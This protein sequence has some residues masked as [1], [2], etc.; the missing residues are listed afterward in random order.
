MENKPELQTV[1]VTFSQ[2][3]NTAGTTAEYETIQINLEFQ[4]GEEEGPFIVLKSKTG[5]SIDEPDDLINLI[6][7]AK[8]IL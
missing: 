2:P 8:K 6:N 5:W 7:R 3:G 4:L 1:S